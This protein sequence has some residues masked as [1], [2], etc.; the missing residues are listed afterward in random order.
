MWHMHIQYMWAMCKPRNFCLC[1]FFLVFL[2]QQTLYEAVIWT[3]LRGLCNRAE[4]WS[5]S[6][7]RTCPQPWPHSLL[8]LQWRLE[9]RRDRQTNRGVLGQKQRERDEMNWWQR[10]NDSKKH[11]TMGGSNSLSKREGSISKGKFP[12]GCMERK[13]DGGK[14]REDIKQQ[15]K[16]KR[17]SW[18]SD[19]K[20][21][22]HWQW[23]TE[24][25]GGKDENMC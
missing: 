21:E 12:K 6:R 1:V 13:M 23:R 3:A 4:H 18:R 11:G 14:G 17:A 7:E 15:R 9:R 2:R 19:G 16:I 20:K 10:A 8:Q 25:D 22:W 5:M 24:R